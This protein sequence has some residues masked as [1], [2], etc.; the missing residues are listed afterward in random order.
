MRR[1]R[2][3]R[4]VRGSGWKFGQPDVVLSMTEEASV[5]AMAPYLTGTLQCRPISPKTNTS[6]CPDWRGEPSVVHCNR[7]RP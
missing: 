4:Q 5:P 6:I 3:P 1:T 7:Q 2:R